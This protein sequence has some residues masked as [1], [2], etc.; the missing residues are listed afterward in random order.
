MK[1]VQ[2]FGFIMFIVTLAM[3]AITGTVWAGVNDGPLAD[4]YDD[5]IIWSQGSVGRVIVLAF[6]LV[7]VTAGVANQSIMAFAVCM[8]AAIGIYNLEGIIEAIFTAVV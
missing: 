8:G 3:L 6:A 7:G 1:R 4:I 2:R 5:L